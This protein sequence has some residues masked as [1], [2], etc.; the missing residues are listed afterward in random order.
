MVEQTGRRRVAAAYIWP[1][2]RLAQFGPGPTVEKEPSHL[3][4]VTCREPRPSHG[5]TG[6]G[7]HQPAGPVRV[8]LRPSQAGL[9]RSRV[10][11]AEVGAGGRTAQL[12]LGLPEGRRS[13][14]GAQ[15]GAGEETPEHQLWE[16][17]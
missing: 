6:P 16:S 7:E 10:H 2:W 17:A 12:P 3:S 5:G 9:V 8:P 15:C 1:R 13:E 14:D 4:V 11:H